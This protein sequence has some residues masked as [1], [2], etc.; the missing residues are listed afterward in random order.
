ML[1]RLFITLS[2]LYPK[3]NVEST[4]QMLEYAN[5]DVE[6]EVWLGESIFMAVIVALVVLYLGNY[7]DQL[8]FSVLAVVCF[9]VYLAG[10]YS[11]PFFVA[12]QRSET[13]EEVLPSALQLMSSNVRAGMTPFQAMKI[14]ARKEFGPLKD[15]LDKA[16]TKAL[17]TESFSDALKGMSERIKLP[18]LERSVKLFIRSIESGGQLA[19]ILEETARDISD[20]IMLRKE[21]VSS[22]KTYTL[23]ILATILLGA[24][25]LLN[26][27]IHFT[28]RLGEMRSSFNT[29]SVESMGL[30]SLLGGEAFTPEFLIN[31]SAVIVVVTSFIAGL[32]IGVIN[33]GEE[34]YGLKYSFILVPVTLV[35]FYSVRHLVQ[36]ILK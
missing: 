20:N 35:I 13:V 16:T 17:G 8:L 6:A 2:K 29:A 28:E 22:T 33:K 27:S 5:L 36:I 32:L 11:I 18:A 3:K 21:L 31:V 19:R 30:G 10:A 25:V 4:R 23:L 34:K 1:R 15:E 26:I 24:P 9:L 7:G 14:S 12:E